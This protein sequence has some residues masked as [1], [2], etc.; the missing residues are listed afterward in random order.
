MTQLSSCVI[1]KTNPLVFLKWPA[2]ALLLV[3]LLLL[4]FVAFSSPTGNTALNLVARI[5]QR[6]A[7]LGFPLV[8]TYNLVEFV[9]NV[10]LFVPLG[11]LLPLAWGSLRRRHLVWT[12][13]AGLAV[14]LGIETIQHFVP[15]RVSDPR[16]LVSNT[17]GTLLGV[18]VIVVWTR[19]KRSDVQ[20]SA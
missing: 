2:R 1:T 6:I 3:F 12:V 4:G 10:V 11:V 7:E 8:P 13:V 20:D 16:D 9:A 19:L 17:F 15:G 18:I 14:S 5:A